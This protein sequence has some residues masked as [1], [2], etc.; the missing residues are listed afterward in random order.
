MIGKYGADAT[1]LGLIAGRDVTTDWMIG[2]NSLE[3]RIRG[4]RNYTNKIWNIGRF[5]SLSTQDKIVPQY[6]NNLPGLL[7]EDKKIISSLEKVIKTVDSDINKY[8]LGNAADK[9]YQFIWHEFADIY[10]EDVKIQNKKT[11]VSYLMPELI[12]KSI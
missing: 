5:I 4:F 1:R 6:R 8:R 7:K 3:E 10:I 9:L 12:L 11:P 2:K